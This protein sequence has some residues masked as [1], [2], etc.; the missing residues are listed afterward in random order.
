MIFRESQEEDGGFFRTSKIHEKSV[1]PWVSLLKKKATYDILIWN[2]YLCD[3][4]R[5]ACDIQKGTAII[6]RKNLVAAVAALLMLTLPL[7]ACFDQPQD[8]PSQGT[9]E[10]VTIPPI[11]I[12]TDP[13]ERELTDTT[14]YT[15][16]LE[17]LFASSP[18]A[19][20]SDF[21][22]EENGDGI[23]ITGYSGG[24]SVIVIPATL[25]EKPVTA[26]G[27][28]AFADMTGLKA[29]SVPDSVTEIGFGAF[30][31]CKNLT[32]LRTP[33]FTCEDN[34]YFGALFGAKTY[35]AQGSAIPAGLSTL[36]LS[37]GDVI[38]DYAFYACR[39]LEAVSLPETI[40]ALGNFAF[41]GCEAL[42]CVTTGH[43]ALTSVGEHVFTNCS[44]LLSL[45]LPATVERMGFAM[46]EGCGKLESLTIPFVGGRTLEHLS[47]EEKEAIESGEAADPVV[48]TGYLG[49]LF[50][51]AHYTF[52]VGY[53]PA[54]LITVTVLEG[55]SSIPA[56]GFFECA[57]VREVILPDGVTSIGRRAFYGCEKLASVT[58]P[59][60]V[61][62]LGDD[63]Y[64]GCIRLES[65]TGGSGLAELGVQTF[66]NCVSLETVILPDAVTHLP[67]ACFSGCVTLK[68][69][70]APGIQ[71]R[72][73]QVFRHCDGLKGT[74]WVPSN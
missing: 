18:V 25:A 14:A 31:G 12:P 67:N 40:T 24:E 15:E 17:T 41:Y 56:N 65:F 52:T 49:Y 58:L 30:A 28:K 51:A 10:A 59:D 50:G 43:T 8:Q 1:K 39:G 9:G 2:V 20:D 73:E 7:S 4:L 11:T 69:L 46:L 68:S 6:M 13:D 19:P 48:E 21:T 26:I 23:R 74:A 66:M 36:V 27:E 5:N 3:P 22:Y 16:R 64:H 54:S 57:S 60:S 61:V 34:P 35:D 62:S 37:G 44:S 53:L 71:T 63:A 45:D 42:V 55:C 72:G 47:E 33:V 32:S 38:P 29:L 70:T